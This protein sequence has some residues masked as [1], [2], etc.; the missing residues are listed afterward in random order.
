MWEKKGLDELDCRVPLLIRAP[1]PLGAKAAGKRTSALAQ[2]VDIMPTLID[3][4]GL[5]ID[6]GEE[7]PLSGVSLKP[8]RRG[9]SC[10]DLSRPAQSGTLI[11]SWVVRCA[12][13]ITLLWLPLL[14]SFDPLVNASIDLAQVLQDP[15]TTGIGNGPNKYAYSQFPRCSCTYAT[16][17][18]DARNGTCD[19][20]YVNNWTHESGATGA[21]NHHVCLFTP[22]RSFDWMGYS[23]R[24]DQ[25]RYTVFV[26]WDGD[27]LSPKWSRVQAEELY[28]H[29]ELT[30][31]SDDDFDGTYSEPLNRAVRPDAEALAAIAK[32]R[33][34]LQKHFSPDSP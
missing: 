24:S 30:P 16:P 11:H 17:T 23:V 32:L 31:R 13:T 25:W 5:P 21:A 7:T 1:G 20:K 29:V 10:P 9:S 2:H 28:A 3:L 34:V 14:P 27:T 6:V 15:P 18:L 33:P 22:S 26:E 8:V 12:L 4:A 19:Q